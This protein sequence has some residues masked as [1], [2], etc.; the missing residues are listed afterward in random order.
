MYVSRD[1]GVHWSVADQLMQL[2]EYIPAVYRADALVFVSTMTDNAAKAGA[3]PGTLSW[4]SMPS[5]EMPVWFN[6]T[7]AFAM[8]GTRSATAGNGITHVTEWDIPYIYMF[9][10]QDEAG[11]TRNTVWR[12]VLNRLTY[13]PVY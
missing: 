5:P 8:V 1:M 7:A 6:A 9:G 4:R 12:G 13:K 11:N 3:M 10:G 2:P